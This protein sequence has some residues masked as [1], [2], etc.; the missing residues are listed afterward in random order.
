MTEWRCICG[1]GDD[2]EW[3]SLM[4]VASNTPD[5]E[6]CGD[7]P[8]HECDHENGECHDVLHQTDLPSAITRTSHLVPPSAAEVRIA[9]GDPFGDEPCVCGT[10]FTCM[11]TEHEAP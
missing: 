5:D 8:P 7:Y 11:A 4:C 9:V 1:S 6:W 2:G 3:H 10:D